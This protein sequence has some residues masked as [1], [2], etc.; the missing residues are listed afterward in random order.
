MVLNTMLNNNSRLHIVKSMEMAGI[1]SLTRR[2]NKSRVR[3]PLYHR[4]SGLKNDGF[5]SRETFREQVL[6]ARR[7]FQ[8]L[9]PDTMLREIGK[10]AHALVITVDDG[11]RDFYDI[12][13]PILREASVPAIVYL[14]TDFIDGK[15]WLWFDKVDYIMR[16][17][18]QREFP[19]SLIDEERMFTRNDAIEILG[20]LKKITTQD[21]DNQIEKLTAYLGV[22]IPEI[23]PEDYMPLSWEQIREMADHGIAFGSHTCTHPILT[24]TDAET[25]RLEI[26]RS[27]ERIQEELGKPV[28]SFAYPN[29][30][31]SESVRQMIEEAGYEYSFSCNYGFFDSRDDRYTLSRIPIGDRPLIYFRQE[32]CGV[33]ILKQRIRRFPLKTDSRS[34]S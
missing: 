31:Y 15:S 22:R 26:L 27:K 28:K 33:D 13:F 7:A 11:Y 5:V 25:A 21:R 9:C 14:T 32:L 24:H 6:Y 12:A 19:F 30:D 2:W 20:R 1:F 17:A 29:G 18:G 8:I 10:C 34:K 4:F 23:P 3:A 16:E